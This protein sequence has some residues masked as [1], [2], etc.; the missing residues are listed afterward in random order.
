M[1]L[2]GLYFRI[3]KFHTPHF[4]TSTIFAHPTLVCFARKQMRIPQSAFGI[5]MH[6]WV[7]LLARTHIHPHI[8]AH[9]PEFMS[10]CDFTLWSVVLLQTVHKFNER[11]NEWMKLETLVRP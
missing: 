4:A 10:H 5:R 2:R 6:N 1:F 3:L 7:L 9:M 11:K 8:L